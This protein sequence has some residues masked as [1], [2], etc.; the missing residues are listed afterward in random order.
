MS[1]IKNRTQCERANDLVSFLYGE[2]NEKEAREFKR[3]LHECAA[4]ESEVASFGQVRESIGAWKNEAL[5]LFISAEVIR[6]VQKKSAVAALREFFNLSP[7]WMKG[8]VA[9]ATLVFCALVFLTIYRSATPKN[10]TQ[11]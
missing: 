2:A 6:P 3:H 4:C 8:A 7:V 1:E 10:P 11:V 9:F 5:G